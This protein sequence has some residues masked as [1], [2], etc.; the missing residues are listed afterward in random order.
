MK[1]FFLLIALTSAVMLAIAA[2]INLMTYNLQ[3]NTGL[4]YQFLRISKLGQ[5]ISESG[6]DL[7]A[8]QEVAGTSN[9]NSLKSATGL[10]GS[11]YD[12]AGDGY[13]IGL[14]WR[15]SLGTPKITNVKVNPTSGSTDS[16]SR[17][18]IIAEFADFCF[19]STHFSLNAVDRDSMV[20]RMIRYANAAGKT[21]F[22]GGDFN[23]QPTYRAM[24]TMQNNNFTVLNN[25]SENTYPS[26][27]PASLIDM[28]LG[29][30][31]NETDKNYSVVSKE[32]PKAPSGVTLTDISDHLPYKVNINIENTTQEELVVTSDGNDAATA[33]TLAWCVSQAEDGA[34]IEFNLNKTEITQTESLTIPAGKT[35][36]IN[37]LNHYN[38]QRIR[39]KGSV[40]AFNVS[41][42]LCLRNTIIS[43]KTTSSIVSTGSLTVEN[44]EFRNNR[45]D[46]DNGGA[47]RASAGACIIRNSL[48]DGNAAG[49]TYGGGAICVYNENSALTL[50]SSTFTGNEAIQG[51]AVSVFKA[52]DMQVTN[53]T[54]SGNKALGGSSNRRGGAIYC[55]N[56]DN[57]TTAEEINC[58]IINSTI[59]GN[60]ALNNG[61]GICA[62]GRTDQKMIRLNLINTILAY[63]VQATAYNDVYNWNPD[64][65]VVI[66][67]KNCIFGTTNYSSYIDNSSKVPASIENANI[68]NELE[69]FETT[70]KAPV[71]SYAGDLPVARLSLGSIAI[72]AGIAQ[73]NG[74]TLPTVDELGYERLSPPAIGAVEYYDLT[75]T[76]NPK[77]ISEKD[78]IR[79]Y[80]QGK[81]ILIN[82]PGRGIHA[83]IYNLNGTFAAYQTG[84][85][86]ITVSLEKF[87]K[88]LY[89]I[90]IN[91]KTYKIV[92]PEK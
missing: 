44:C 16:E 15:S 47:I 26:S 51:G 24:V 89:I 12:I 69:T 50:E 55:A 83:R 35:I 88:N 70:F 45:S 91:A 41:G 84:Y 38:N 10:A 3:G 42:T 34:V 71:L 33:G 8:V 25:L 78:N 52:A 6:A 60:S 54:F 31:K 79:I 13:G 48:F 56:P 19:I 32:I 75:A 36:T 61:G 2:N 18:Y 43:D 29:F 73:F 40:K 23:A 64:T 68:F 81:K 30:R 62:Y 11:W 57:N 90:M 5:V 22:V 20:A 92:I 27:A 82:N 63:N 85:D 74:Y 86:E 14:L 77:N 72:S 59:T 7:V 21:V 76:K 67:A 87:P 58:T 28:I 53:C 4:N 17:A 1:R 49:G 66:T 9:F 80:V 39:L 37:G 46:A 65:R